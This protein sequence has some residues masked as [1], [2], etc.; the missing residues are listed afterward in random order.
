MPAT[1][2][3]AAIGALHLAYAPSLLGP[4]QRH[5]ANPVR[6]NNASTRPGGTPCVHN[7]K[8]VLPV[9]D[10][11]HTYGGAIRPLTF[12]TLTPDRVVT[13]AGA[14]IGQ[15]D[16]FAPYTEGMHTLAGVGPVTLIDA[17]YTDLSAYGIG[18]QAWREVRQL[19]A[20]LFHP[21]GA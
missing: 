3:T 20:R 13:H 8:L 11:T 12:D 9:Q 2:R 21:K 6:L 17:K 18:L 14:A 15:N 7:G 5:H 19:G 1:S 4:W 10:C 16:S